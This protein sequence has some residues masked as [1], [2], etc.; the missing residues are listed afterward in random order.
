MKTD[1]I[2]NIIWNAGSIENLVDLKQ[3]DETRR[4]YRKRLFEEAQELFMD[5]VEE[6]GLNNTDDIKDETINEIVEYLMGKK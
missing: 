4:E 5:S 2:Q 6:L 1:I 3:D